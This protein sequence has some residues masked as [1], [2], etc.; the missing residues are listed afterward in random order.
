[1]TT[2]LRNYSNTTA[3]LETKRV[4][5]RACVDCSADLSHL[6]HGAKRCHNC[7][8]E[9]KKKRNH[10][11]RDPNLSQKLAALILL[12]FK[13]PHE[14]AKTMRIDEILA[15][16]EWDHYPVAANAARDLGWTAEQT[17]HPSNL[18][19]LLPAEHL[20]K[21]RIIDTPQAAKGKRLSKAQEAHRRAM[22]KQDAPEKPAGRK[23]KGGGFR[24]HRKFDGTPVW[25]GAQ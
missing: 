5:V 8:H 16:P 23:M 12:H 14:R 24:G 10:R 7:A 6:G 19:P 13:I 2:V 1:M 9:A 11:V 3:T 15:L 21:T 22:L 17:N 25:K 20:E 4:T 18:Q